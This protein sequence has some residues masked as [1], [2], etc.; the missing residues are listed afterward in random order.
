M[1]SPAV[2]VKPREAAFAVGGP[3]VAGALLGLPFGIMA[4]FDGALRL[5][6]VSFGVTLIM[7]PALQI[8]C[9]FGGFA[10]SPRQTVIAATEGLG[11]AGLVLLGLA[12]VVV[13]LLASSDA[14][15]TPVRVGTVAVGLSALVGM[16]VM[17]RTLFGDEPTR[18]AKLLFGAWAAI[19]NGIASSLFFETFVR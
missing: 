15:S 5:P 12:P 10:V 17:R 19:G 6:L 2:L 11:R 16:R 18:N 8:A 4:L 9:A 3:L 14:V 13:F 7:L 1:E